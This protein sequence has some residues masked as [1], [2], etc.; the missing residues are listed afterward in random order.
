[1]NRQPITPQTEPVGPDGLTFRERTW[2]KAARQHVAEL[3]RLL[4]ERGSTAHYTVGVA[5]LDVVSESEPQ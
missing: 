3:N 4:S 1:M 5:G 2:L